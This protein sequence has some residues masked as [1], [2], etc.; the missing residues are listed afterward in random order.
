MCS[1]LLDSC[2]PMDC[3]PPG[4]SVLGISQAKILKWLAISFS[5]GIFLTQGYLPNPG[6]E[7]ASPALAGGFFTTAPPRKPQMVI[8]IAKSQ[9]V[10]EESK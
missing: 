9:D 3:S 1:V 6:I 8:I 2:D 7:P 4:A 5:R 10:C